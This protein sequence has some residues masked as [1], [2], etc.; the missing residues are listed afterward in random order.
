LRKLD[1]HIGKEDGWCNL[2]VEIE[3]CLEIVYKY[4]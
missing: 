3:L 1:T 2:G 4:P